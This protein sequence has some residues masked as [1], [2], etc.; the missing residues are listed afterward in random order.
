MLTIRRLNKPEE[1]NL[2]RIFALVLWKDVE[3][4]HHDPM[5]NLVLRIK[6][7]IYIHL[8]GRDPEKTMMPLRATTGGA[9]KQE[10][11]ME[12]STTAKYWTGANKCQQPCMSVTRGE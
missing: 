6:L 4:T 2:N 1:R 12:E 11:Y 9:S 10:T 7:I 3:N 8:K 5:L